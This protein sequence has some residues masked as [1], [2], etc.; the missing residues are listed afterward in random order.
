MSTAGYGQIDPAQIVQQSIDNYE[1]D[2]RAAC[3]SWAYTQ[4]DITESDGTKEIEV[5]EVTP[6]AG[7]PYER[8]VRKNGQPLTPAEQRKE[9]R[10]YEK[11]ARQRA[12]ETPAE[13]ESRIRKYETDR[14]FIK[15]VPRAYRF[16]LLGEEV[17][18]GR[19]V[20]VISMA[21]RPDFTPSTP[22]AAMLEH[23]EGRLW[24]DKADVQ[25]AKAE[26]H[27]KDTI[28][29]GWIL[30]RIKP[31]TGFAIEQSRVANGL[32]MPRMVK[33]TGSAHVMLIHSKAINEELTYSGYRREGS[34]SADNRNTNAGGT[35]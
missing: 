15:E 3:H 19:P 25:W 16:N 17:V 14:D 8:L 13:R 29:I 9:D 12:E 2:W 27:V 32:W 35:Q 22:H 5:S 7:T 10:K 24:I 6:L 26:A 11:T 28:S 23:I 33:I 18:E 20:W 21:P 4:T 1:R 30:A 31:G 34:V